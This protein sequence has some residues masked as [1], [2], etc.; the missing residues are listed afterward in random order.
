M[1][2]LFAFVRAIGPDFAVLI[3]AKTGWGMAFRR[4]Q[5]LPKPPSIRLEMG[6]LKN[7]SDSLHRPSF[8]SSLYTLHLHSTNFCFSQFFSSLLF[9]SPGFR[10]FK[11][12]IFR[13]TNSTSSLLRGETLCGGQF[14]SVSRSWQSVCFQ[15]LNLHLILHDFTIYSRSY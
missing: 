6:I 14:V 11:W 13:W 2:I 9:S 8:P 5:R 1:L 10:R 4:A 12:S 15:T 3:G 7:S